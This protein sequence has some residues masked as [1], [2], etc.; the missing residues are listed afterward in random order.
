MYEN[1]S[2]NVK[3]NSGF[4]GGK[5]GIAR[6]FSLVLA[7]QKYGVPAILSDLTNTIRHGDVCLLGADDPH[8][9]EV[10][11]SQNINKRTERQIESIKNIHGYL[12][13]DVG[14][15]SGFK[16]MKRVSLE[17]DEIHFND[18]INKAIETALSG[19]SCRLGESADERKSEVDHLW[20]NC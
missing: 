3:Q 11:S 6:E 19:K 20:V 14:N 1:D 17:Y 7:A 15:V 10:K 18:V 5:K 12:D 8:L 13:S 16:G 4:I 9:I 2:P